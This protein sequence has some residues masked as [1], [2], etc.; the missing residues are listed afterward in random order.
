VPPGDQLGARVA[1]V[2]RSPGEQ[3]DRLTAG[4]FLPAEAAEPL[5]RLERAFTLVTQAAPSLEKIARASKKKI[6]PRRP[7]EVLIDEA[8]AAGVVSAGE[9]AI[10]R[11]AASA[12]AEALQVD[13]FPLA[14]YL[15]L[16]RTSSTFPATAVLSL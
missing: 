8:E 3:R 13:S 7:P 2:L 4:L 11:Q 6:L 16:D 12:R 9:A 1:D 14:E 10:L 15:G 5:A